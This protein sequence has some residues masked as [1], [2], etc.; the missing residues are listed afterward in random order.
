MK[1][2]GLHNPA[3]ITAIASTDRGKKGITDAIENANAGVAAT[4]S[5]IKGVLKAG[6]FLGVGYYVYKKVFDGFSKLKEDKRYRPSNIS[7]GM[8]K[9]K[10]EAIYS[11]LYGINITSAGFKAVKQ[12]LTGVN[13]NGFIKI[14][15]EFG[16]RK[17]LNPMSSKMNLVEWISDEFS[18]SELVQL[19]FIVPNFF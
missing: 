1:K 13:H 12:N 11:A 18:Q 9:N 14:Y 3:V 19:R 15:N 7:T 10:A 4:A 17:G 16:L 5:I 2:Q 8:A 6:L